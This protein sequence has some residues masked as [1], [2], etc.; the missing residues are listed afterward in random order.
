MRNVFLCLSMF[1]LCILVGNA[2]EN[3]IKHTV[4]KGETVFQLSR[5]YN[6]SPEE[7]YAL[8]PSAVDVIKIGEELSIPVKDNLPAQQSSLNTIS[9]SS[10]TITYAV[11]SGDTKY[12]LARRFGISIEEFERQNP[13]TINGLQAGHILK[14]QSNEKA[15]RVANVDIKKAHLVLKGQTLWGISRDNGLTVEQLVN[16][17]SDILN[18]ILQIGQVLKIPYPYNINSSDSATYVVQ[19]GDTKFGLSKKYGVTIEE[20]ERVNPHIVR[21]LMAGH[22]IVIPGD[23]NE[24]VSNNIPEE[25]NPEVETTETIADSTAPDSVEEIIQEEPTTERATEFTTQQPKEN[26]NASNQTI[27]ST[28]FMDYEVRPKETLYGLSK[29]AGMTISDFVDLNP[30]VANGV[31]IGMIVKMPSKDFNATT[32]TVDPVLATKTSTYKYADLSK[33]IQVTKRNQIALF[34]PFSEN[35]FTDEYRQNINFKEVSDDFIREHLEFYRGAQIAE[36]SARSL[37][38]DFKI[39][40]IETS[41]SKRNTRAGVLAKEHGLENYD[42]V[43]LPFYDDIEEVAALTKTNNIPVISASS[44]ITEHGMNN[45]YNGVPSLNSSRNIM[46]DYMTSLGGNIIVVCDVARKE[47]QSYISNYTPTAK[48]VEVNKKGI[49]NSDELVSMFD[50]NKVNYVILESDKNSV[51]LSTTNLLLGQ[52]SEHAIQLALLDKSLIPNTD[53]IS[54]KRFIILQML[55]PS[56][57]SLNQSSLASNFIEAYKKTYSVEPGVNV[58]YGFDLT[59]DTLLRLSQGKNFEASAKSDITEYTNLKFNYK[60]NN[61]GSY[62]NKGMYIIQYN[63]DGTL[64]EV[65]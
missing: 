4:S 32:E 17:N 44:L 38:L 56:L 59:F 65:K 50:K 31:K 34:L 10:N 45:I 35:K 29:K 63:T 28:S 60:V 61:V 20:L 3:I 64:K 51:F 7:I 26:V 2:Q 13:H 54:Q 5:R 41:N 11:V 42:A 9:S 33:S 62:E 40:I 1:F 47:S 48:F 23:S 21:M 18:G 15:S 19:R 55:H 6:V 16:A 53:E 36:D 39:N 22:T 57:T 27:A 14:I 52:L 12:S 49:F 43:I 24:V 25:S 58:K 30:E 46:L 37:G 8:N